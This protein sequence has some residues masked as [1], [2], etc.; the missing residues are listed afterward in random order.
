MRNKIACVVGLCCHP[1]YVPFFWFKTVAFAEQSA[2]WRRAARTQRDPI[3][4]H[5][6][7]THNDNIPSGSVQGKRAVIPRWPRKR[8]VQMSLASFYANSC[9]LRRERPHHKIGKEK[10][11]SDLHQLSEGLR[12]SF[13]PA[14]G[15]CELQDLKCGPP[16]WAKDLPVRNN[17]KIEWRKSMLL[18][19]PLDL[20]C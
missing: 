5:A 15:D 7:W 9:I 10:K 4:H 20:R 14:G 18:L 17:P 11:K 12:G 8:R 13:Q 16:R 2:G 3:R 6:F 19:K 1:S